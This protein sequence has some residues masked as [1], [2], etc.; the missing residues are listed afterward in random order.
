[1]AISLT[2]CI[3]HIEMYRMRGTSKDV[4]ENEDDAQVVLAR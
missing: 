2:D 3:P 4:T 1:M